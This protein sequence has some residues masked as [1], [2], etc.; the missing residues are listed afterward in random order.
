[1]NKYRYKN[2]TL[3]KQ[4]IA[5]AL[6]THF[7]INLAIQNSES[8]MKKSYDNTYHCASIKRYEN[9]KIVSSYCKNRWCY[10][11]NRIRT[12]INIKNY[13]SDISNF[14]D[15][16]FI[17]LTR[18]TV[19]IKDLPMRID[20]MELS[21]RQLYKYSN[22]KRKDPFKNG[23]FL[24]GIRS[25]ETTIR[26]DKKYH[27]HMHLIVDGKDNAEWIIDEWLKRNKDASPK[28]Q[29]LK[30]ADQNALLEIFKYS[31]KMS[32]DL[33]KTANFKRLDSLFTVL[34]GKRTL[35]AF[36]GVKVPKIDIN[37]EMQ[38]EAQPDNYLKLRLGD[39]LSIWVWKSDLCD[40]INYETGEFL[41]GE[42]LPLKI[43][44]IV[45]YNRK[46]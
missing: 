41:V 2:E 20:E 14:I 24:K 9:G 18:P 1:M 25:M 37:E 13:S 3:S 6:T 5:K 31:V 12:A 46:E 15:P 26:P 32:V 28:S 45:E 17:T 16:Y 44:D 7:S 40:W 21:W 42:D 29:N 23:I 35:A 43:K 19:G 30:S 10:T 36:G 33:Q 27:Y 4:Q 38:L 39:E 11:C 8:P 22:D 34:K